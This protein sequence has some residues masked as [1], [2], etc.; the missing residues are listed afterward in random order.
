MVRMVCV[1]PR[2]SVSATPAAPGPSDLLGGE[3]GQASQE[4]V[5]GSAEAEEGSAQVG[6]Q[7]GLGGQHRGH[8]LVATARDVPGRAPDGHGADGRAEAVD[9]V[10]LDLLAQALLGPEVV[11]DQPHRDPGVG[12]DPAH[13][14]ALDAVPGKERQ[15]RV[16]DA[17]TRR[18]VVPE[19]LGHGSS[20][21]RH[22]S[23]TT[24][25]PCTFQHICYTNV[26]GSTR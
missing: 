26:Q 13:G 9:D 4:V 18:E 2:R 3:L 14:R 19:C 25:P 20:L 23:S 8:G 21:R 1:D 15:R 5:V 12:G 17:G 7:I 16:A 24:H 6:D 10:G 22:E 11:H